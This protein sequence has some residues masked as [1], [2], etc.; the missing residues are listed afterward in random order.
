RCP[1][2]IVIPFPS[3]DNL[4]SRNELPV[5]AEGAHFL[6]FRAGKVP[7]IFATDSHVRSDISGAHLFWS[8][9]LSQLLRIGPRNVNASR[10]RVDKPCDFE[11]CFLCGF[12]IHGFAFELSR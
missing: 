9:P 10:R 3:E 8:K 11:R 1:I 4:L 5:F 12:L 6:P 7:T 2:L